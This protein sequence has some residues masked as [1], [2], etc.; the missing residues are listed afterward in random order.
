MDLNQYRAID[1]VAL[2]LHGK[3]LEIYY[4][5]HHPHVA[6]VQEL[7]Q[8]LASAT[9]EERQAMLGQAKALIACGTA[10]EK[11]IETIPAKPEIK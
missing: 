10:V 11:A 5:I 1:P 7:Q 4:L 6:S 3:A 2:I 8:A 9:P